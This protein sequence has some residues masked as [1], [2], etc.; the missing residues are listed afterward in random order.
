[1]APNHPDLFTD[2]DGEVFLPYQP[3]PGVL[4]MP[5]VAIWGTGL[6]QLTF[7]MILGALN[8]V[9]FWYILRLLNVSRE[10]K[11]LLIPFFAFGTAHFYSATTGSLWFYNHVAAVFFVLLAITFLLRRDNVVLP[12][13]CLGAA[14]LSRQPTVLAVPAFI[15]F[16][17]E[18]RNPGALSGIHPGEMVAGLVQLHFSR[19]RELCQQAWDSVQAAVRDPQARASVGI[20]LATLIPFAIISLWYND[21]RFGSLFDSGLD[22]I[23]DK[24]NGV[25]YTQYLAAGATERFEWF[26]PRNIPIHLYTIF[27]Q[28]PIFTNDATMFRPS[29]FGMSV[30]LTSSPMVFAFFVRR[31]DPLK[32]ACWLA[33]ALVAIPTLVYYSAG[34]VQF[35]YRYIMDYLPFLMILTAFGFEDNRSPR[36]L[37]IKIGLVVLSIAIGFWGR[38]WA[39]RLVW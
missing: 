38:Y 24:Y 22:E 10:T 27:L 34:W 11:L 12:A 37:W 28:P 21:V 33:I 30:L 31:R 26:D 39:T 35:G 3:M 25:A 23:Y 6:T 29:E 13:L 14:A 4:L 9:L 15:Y 17:I 36:S 18:Q 7:S 16:M 20:L 8:V 32:I 2:V 1:V 19:L 5:I